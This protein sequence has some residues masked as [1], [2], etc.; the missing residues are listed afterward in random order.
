MKKI[1]STLF[2]LLLY[3]GVLLQPASAFSENFDVIGYYT[4]S[5]TG[6]EE[7]L[8]FNIELQKGLQ[9]PKEYHTFA[10]DKSQGCFMIIKTK[11]GEKILSAEG[12]QLQEIELTVQVINNDNPAEV[13]IKV[14]SKCFYKGLSPE[15][16]SILVTRQIKH[17]AVLKSPSVD[18]TQNPEFYTIIETTNQGFINFKNQIN[19]LKNKK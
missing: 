12:Y 18:L 14:F 9:F 15:G 3:C 16:N 13:A 17:E 8:F 1:F 7:N 19:A 6:T 10:L 5:W 2:L 4:F 11:E